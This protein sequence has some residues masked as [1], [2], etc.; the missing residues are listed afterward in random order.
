MPEP[1]AAPAEPAVVI[2][3]DRLEPSEP[4]VIVEADGE[5]SAQ[6]RSTTAR[7]PTRAGDEALEAILGVGD[8][9]D[10]NPAVVHDRL[11]DADSRPILLD[12]PRR[13]SPAMVIDEPDDDEDE[14]RPTQA[15]R[16]EPTTSSCSSA[17]SRAAAAPRS[18][19]S[20]ASARWAR[21]SRA[22]RSPPATPIG[23]AGRWS[24]SS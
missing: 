19:P 12:R 7:T 16:V 10:E 4:V 24:T 20:S 15:T 8:D 23:R 21:W 6:H 5:R 2:A 22:P 9:T 17:R 14:A 18:G 11:A 1:E 13:P 3:V